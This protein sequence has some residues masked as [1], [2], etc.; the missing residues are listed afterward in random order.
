M[1]GMRGV[2]TGVK[3]PNPGGA[4]TSPDVSSEKGRKELTIKNAKNNALMGLASAL[5]KKSGR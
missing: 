1:A 3:V 5:T 2:P 4:W